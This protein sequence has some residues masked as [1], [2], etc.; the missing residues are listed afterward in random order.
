VW[1]FSPA[2]IAAGLTF[3]PPPNANGTYDMVLVAIAT[4]QANGD[5]AQSTAP[6]RV[7]VAPVPDHV[8][9]TTSPAQGP[10]D[11]T[12]AFGDK[13]GI[14]IND[15]D[16]SEVLTGIAITGVPTGAVL[17]WDTGIAGGTVTSLGGG[18]YQ[19]SRQRN[20]HP[21]AACLDD[22]R[23]AAARRDRHRAHHQGHHDRCRRSDQHRDDRAADRR[24]APSPTSRR[25]LG[26]TFATEEDTTV[27]L[28]GV[29]G[30]LVDTG[31]LGS[32]D[33]PHHRRAGRRLVQRRHKSRRRRVELH[34]G[35]NGG[36][37]EL[38]AAGQR[39]RHLRHDADLHGNR[40]GEQRRRPEQ[41]GRSAWSSMRRPTR[42]P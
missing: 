18:S 41:R 36:G 2:D 4:E 29:G 24:H 26:G 6:F 16:A 28:T 31:R 32:A 33:L 40:D 12:I 22:D 3:L 34:A 15:T 23:A 39:A 37:L 1:A 11:T 19:I 14:V 5:T 42:R 17:G 8:D 35:A 13:I 7:I 38:H 30:A 25:R 10:E 9:V 27:R 21:R 20:R